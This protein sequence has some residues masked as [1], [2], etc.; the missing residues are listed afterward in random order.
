MN[1]R[2]CCGFVVWAA[3]SGIILACSA[4]RSFQSP[5]NERGAERSGVFPSRAGFPVDTAIARVLQRRLVVEVAIALRDPVVRQI[6]FNAISSSTFPEHKVH[7]DSFLLN[8]GDPLLAA[9]GTA[10][11]RTKA[12][13]LAA[14]DS[15]PDFELYLPIPEHFASWQGNSN[16]LVASDLRDGEIPFVVDLQGRPVLGIGPDIP[17]QTPTLVLVPVETDFSS[18]PGS[19]AY[20]T[21]VDCPPPCQGTACGGGGGSTPP[22]NILSL[23][24]V[25][26]S[27][28]HEGWPNGSPEFELWVY[29]GDNNGNPLLGSST[30][31]PN[32]PPGSQTPNGSTTTSLIASGCIGY[33]A[34]NAKH[35]GYQA[36]N[37]WRTYGSPPPIYVNSLVARNDT[38]N[39][40]ILVSENDDD[41]HCDN[42]GGIFPSIGNPNFQFDDDD[43]VGRIRFPLGH[44][45]AWHT[46]T[47]LD[48]DSLWLNFAP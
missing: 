11:G 34:T 30:Y 47:F 4:E 38:L 31:D 48:V 2:R 1:W 9:I 22:P 13:V 33:Y 12:K 15:L 16:I 36:I 14:L 18:A 6:V 46:P 32:N 27:N 25:E 20:T 19:I 26:I 45:Q 8:S 5:Q 28:D 24:G 42:S 7:F 43:I 10:G 40:W 39:W 17:P 41:G 37:T 44:L 23:F 21:C 35:W 3:G 29:A